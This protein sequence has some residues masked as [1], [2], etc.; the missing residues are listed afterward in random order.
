MAAMAIGVLIGY[1]VPGIKVRIQ[2]L[3]SNDVQT[4][5]INPAVIMRL[6][7]PI[8]CLTTHIWVDEQSISRECGRAG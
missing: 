3:A 8:L 2:S 6:R 1:F 4:P 5:I 7:M